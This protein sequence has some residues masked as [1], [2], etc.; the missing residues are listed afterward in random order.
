MSVTRSDFF[1][2]NMQD[3]FVDPPAGEA[4]PTGLAVR[5]SGRP[6][7]VQ[8]SVGNEA[9]RVIILDVNADGQLR[10]QSAVVHRSTLRRDSAT[11]AVQPGVVV[12]VRAGVSTPQTGWGAHDH[13]SQGMVESIDLN[14]MA[15]VLFAP[16]VSEHWWCQRCELES[17]PVADVQ[18]VPNSAGLRVGDVVQVKPGLSQPRGGWGNVGPGDAGRVV[19][20]VQRHTPHGSFETVTVGFPNA[21]SWN[22]APSE[23]ELFRGA[24]GI[25]TRVQVSPDVQRPQ[26]GMPSGIDHASVGEVRQI[27]Y[28]AIAQVSYE[29]GRRW[30]HFGISELQ[31]AT[32]P[33]PD[34]TR[35][36][37]TR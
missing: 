4:Y 7:T 17:V 1:E 2:F 33:P 21:P 34:Y 20:H 12:R 16:D 35:P 19:G 28:N 26:F 3:A 8:G 10:G 9:V 30:S 5:H 13:T 18:T 11:Q 25:G 29:A 31:P 37:G 14:G 6:A 22:A 15:R 32:P 36:E 23:L 27:L 24:V